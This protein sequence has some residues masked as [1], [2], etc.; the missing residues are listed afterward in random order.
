MSA[1][2]AFLSLRIPCCCGQPFWH[3]ARHKDMQSKIFL[4]AF[5]ATVFGLSCNK[6]DDQAPGFDLIYQTDFLLPAGIG[7]FEVH[8]F[9][10]KNIPTRYQQSLDQHGKTDGDIKSILTAQAV[11]SGVYSDA[12]FDIIDQV[13]VRVFDASDPTDYVEIAYRYP[14]PLDPGNTLPLIP[15]LADTKRFFNKT[16]VS[17]DIVIWL[18]NTTQLETEVRLNLQMKATY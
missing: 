13:S 10:I 5:C 17:L 18:R 8:H 9:Q 14:T 6:D 4:L 7:V 2:F 3:S 15:S 12:N 16:R 1:A 11:L